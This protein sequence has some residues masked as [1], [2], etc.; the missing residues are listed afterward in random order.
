MKE[1]GIKIEPINGSDMF[2]K[3]T[4]DGKE[5]NGIR[6]LDLHLDC[7]GI[8][9][10]YLTLNALNTNVDVTV[11]DVSMVILDGCKNTIDSTIDLDKNTRV[12]VE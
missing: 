11:A 7:D 5:V 4:V 12:K 8:P 10:L 3:V 6:E 1:R 9:T 2:Y